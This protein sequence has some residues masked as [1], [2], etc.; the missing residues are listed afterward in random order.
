LRRHAKAP[1]AGSTEASGNGRGRL[2]PLAALFIALAALALAAAPALAA[3][4]SGYGPVATN[5]SVPG[6]LARAAVEDSTGNLLIADPGAGAVDVFAPDLSPGGTV[7]LLTSFPVAAP[8]GIAIDQSSGAVYVSDAGSN[9]IIRFTSDGAPVPTYTEDAGFTSPALG[10]G[11]GQVGNFRSALAVDPANHDLLV[12]D[13]GNQRVSRYADT[14][15]FLGSFDGSGSAIGKFN[16]I[17]DI[18]VGVSGTYVVDYLVGD[19]GSG[20]AITRVAQFDAG[21]S[22]LKTLDEE[23]QIVVVAVDGARLLAVGRTSYL[24]PSAQLYVFAGGVLG[25]LSDLP[26]RPFNPNGVPAGATVAGLAL[27][28]GAA[29]RVYTV[30]RTFQNYAGG[31]GIDVLVPS[32]AVEADSLASPDPR[33]AHLTGTVNP[34]TT[35]TGA[36]AGTL[37][38]FE[39]SLQGKNEW[40]STPDVDL[41]SG[42]ADLS[43]SAD[44][45]G[46][47]P[48]KTYLVRV[49]ATDT[50]TTAV[51]PAATVTTA[52]EAPTVETGK[53]IEVGTDR[54]TLTGKVSPF[55]LQ[56]TYYFEYGETTDYG[57]LV[58]VNRAGV[59][60]NGYEPRSVARLISGLSPGS[61]YHY[62][63]VAVS[64]A[65]ISHGADEVLTTNAESVSAARAYEMVSPVEKNG[66]P[67]SLDFVAVQ[68]ADSGDSLLYGFRK[69]ALPGASSLP[70]IP[71]A[72]STRGSSGWNTSQLDFPLDNF[73]P[74]N[75]L[76]FGTVA[77]SKDVSRFA[78]VTQR[79]LS[80]GDGAVAGAWNLYIREPTRGRDLFVASDPILGVLAGNEMP[81]RFHG[82]SDDLSTMV[83]TAGSQTY[84]IREGAGV[85]LISRYPDGSPAPHAQDPVPTL[86]GPANPVSDDGTRVYMVLGPDPSQHALYLREN[87]TTI[88]VSVS[89]V[90]GASTEP[91]LA[92]YLGASEDGRFVEFL[93]EGDLTSDAPQSGDPVVAYR[94]DALT[95]ELTYVAPSVFYPGYPVIADP[96][97][98]ALYYGAADGS[99]IYAREG[100]V[101]TIAGSDPVKKQTSENGRYLAF[102]ATE[103]LTSYD[104]ASK[105]E[106]YLY[107]SQTEE[108]SCPS[109]RTDGLSPTGNAFMG[110]A[111][112]S[113][114]NRAFSR[115][116]LDDGTVYF[117]TP[118]P[119]VGSDVNHTRDVYGYRDGQLTL[120]SGGKDPSNSQVAT[121]TPDG[122]NVFFISSDRLVRQDR[123]TTADMYDARV[124]GGIAA[125][126]ADSPTECVAEDCRKAV[127]PPPLVPLIGSEARVG[128]GNRFTRRHKHRGKHHKKSKRIHGHRDHHIDRRQAR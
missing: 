37:A 126:N 65:G 67:V 39:Y 18:A 97:H 29:R 30:T 11:A 99:L 9:R 45:S 105:A 85:S 24:A 75:L 113:E 114:F 4:V 117:D 93:A 46:L 28:P 103:Q 89:Q 51:S 128:A 32:P 80:A 31:A 43:I 101:K 47:I 20:S 13:A 125:Q 57:S 77:A 38:H 12:G 112:K 21:G 42:D 109:C 87:G 1:S 72:M 91:V 48:H 70:F 66:T 55:G 61:I 124:G 78:V 64:S 10:T 62:R 34:E 98:A 60:G 7:T 69:A 84:A 121:V 40:I 116:L 25:A 79:K 63:L 95:H 56:S 102:I 88:P 123:D 19:I 35:A 58:P 108:L 82:T 27:F 94:Y 100:T 33:S 71:R 6:N 104:N 107:D 122:A 50:Q 73:I 115:V 44:V 5:E 36:A 90:P 49:V 96:T 74:G 76:A 83:L 16:S 8:Y 119:L 22:Y 3:P 26:L 86:R 68:A 118:D 53:A 2:G 110:Q 127:A 106:L 81:F 54:A 92:E 15:A 14:G 52:D 59:A 111:D 120:I 17:Q 41:G 23:H